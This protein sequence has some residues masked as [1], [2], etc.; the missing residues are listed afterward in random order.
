MRK[1][2]GSSTFLELY[3]EQII[4]LQ[5]FAHMVELLALCKRKLTQNLEGGL[6]SCLA[7]LNH[8]TACLSDS[9][10]MNVLHV[11][12]YYYNLLNTASQAYEMKTYA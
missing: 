7:L 4:L 5:Y 9:T 8:I 6:V 12:C 3:G 11:M 2:N 1:T 10:I